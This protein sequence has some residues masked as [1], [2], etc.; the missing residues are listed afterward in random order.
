MPDLTTDLVQAVHHILK[1][2]NHG[3]R[4]PFNGLALFLSICND[5][6]PS[7]D[8]GQTVVEHEVERVLRTVHLCDTH[9]TGRATSNVEPLTHENYRLVLGCTKDTIDQ[10]AKFL[11]DS[12]RQV[13]EQHGGVLE[14]AGMRELMNKVGG[15]ADDVHLKNLFEQ[16]AGLHAVQHTAAND[17][18][19][20][21]LEQLS[22]QLNKVLAVSK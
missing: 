6:I 2:G 14:Q 15:D 4:L 17:E 7:L 10:L 16:V 1:E 19:V 22:E 18:A 3:G 12:S 8:I 11:R 9:T 13:V 21:Q 20:E 5:N